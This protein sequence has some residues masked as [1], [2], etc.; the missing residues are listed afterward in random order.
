MRNLLARILAVFIIESTGTI[1]GASLLHMNTYLA[2]ALAGILAVYMVFRD[3]AKDFLNDGKLTQDEI[4]A[5][6]KKVSD[7]E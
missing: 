4:D 5:V 6:F 2:A 7:K 1:A 3:L